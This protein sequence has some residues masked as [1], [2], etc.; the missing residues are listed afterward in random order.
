MPFVVMCPPK[1]TS[2]LE[3]SPV[4]LQQPRRLLLGGPYPVSVAKHPMAGP[5]GVWRVVQ[6]NN[7]ERHIRRHL[8]K[9]VC[10]SPCGAFHLVRHAVQGKHQAVGESH[11][12]VTLLLQGWKR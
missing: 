8:V 1:T 3:W 7:D 5:T 12:V 9:S 4:L 6:D 2:G 11:G 10:R